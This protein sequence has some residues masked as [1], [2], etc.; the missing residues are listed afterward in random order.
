MKISSETLQKHFSWGGKRLAAILASRKK[1][2]AKAFTLLF[3]AI[4]SIGGPATAVAHHSVSAEFDAT[5]RITLTGSITKVAWTN[6]HSYFYVDVKDPKTGKVVNWFCELGSPN[7]LVTL[8]WTNA[9][10]KTGMSVNL[11]G[12]VARDGSHKV[13]A[14]NI[15]ADGSPLIAWPSER[16]KP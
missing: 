3:I 9:T 10:L 6:P 12:I 7:M 13:I 4:V 15:V 8:G 16:A 11:T 2:K 5:H 14:R 1:M